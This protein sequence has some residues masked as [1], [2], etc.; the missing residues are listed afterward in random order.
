MKLLIITLLL[1]LSST[2]LALDE[3]RGVKFDKPSNLD[4]LGVDFL[5]APKQKLGG[6]IIM[7]SFPPAKGLSLLG[8]KRETYL[9]V[10]E[11]SDGVH[12]KSVVMIVG[13]Y[14]G[15]L[16]TDLHN[17]LLKKYKLYKGWDA[18]TQKKFNQGLIS[19]LNNY[20]DNGHITLAISN[21]GNG[22]VKLMITYAGAEGA[23]NVRKQLSTK[24]NDGL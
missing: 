21:E 16:Y 18:A 17:Q 9:M 8:E 12:L 7:M 24:P 13:A 15:P 20:Y 22:V 4:K 2:V 19:S 10:R 5:R 3:F 6:D 11:K 14:T 23:K 1:T